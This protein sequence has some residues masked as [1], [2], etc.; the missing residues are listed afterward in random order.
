MVFLH[1]QTA[2]LPRPGDEHHPRI[3]SPCGVIPMMSPARPPLKEDHGDPAASWTFPADADDDND[4]DFAGSSRRRRLRPR[5]RPG[6]PRSYVSNFRWRPLP[7]AS[8]GPATGRWRKYL[9]ATSATS[10]STATPTATP[11]PRGCRWHLRSGWWDVVVPMQWHPAPCVPRWFVRGLPAD[12]CPLHLLTGSG[13]HGGEIG[14]AA[15]GD[16][17]G[18]PVAAI[19]SPVVSVVVL[20]LLGAGVS[21]FRSGRGGCLRSRGRDTEAG[22]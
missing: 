4:D 9:P 14:G 7:K 12:P 19:V 18:N 20:A 15:Q 5:R 17:Q 22:L 21:Y 10:T 11:T 8:A 6:G 1:A 16:T 13:G 2:S 3:F